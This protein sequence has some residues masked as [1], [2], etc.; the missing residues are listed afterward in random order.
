MELFLGDLPNA[1]SDLKSAL[2]MSEGRLNV[3]KT[4]V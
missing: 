2:S 4:T 1:E 3:N